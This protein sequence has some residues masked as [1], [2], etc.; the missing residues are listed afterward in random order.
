MNTADRVSQ[1]CAEVISIC[2]AGENEFHFK[3]VSS[4]GFIWNFFS[5]LLMLM[6]AKQ[7]KFQ[8]KR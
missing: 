6:S 4:C 1:L 2:V 5:V 7:N 8:M 3:I